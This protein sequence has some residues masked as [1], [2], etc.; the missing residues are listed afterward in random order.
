LYNRSYIFKLKQLIFILLWRGGQYLLLTIVQGTN[1]TLPPSALGYIFLAW[2]R[3]YIYVIN[4]AHLNLLT[5]GNSWDRFQEFFLRIKIKF[6][7]M[8]THL[9]H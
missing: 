6:F 9:L 7:N 8:F 2:S 5:L 4:F 3:L 1:Y